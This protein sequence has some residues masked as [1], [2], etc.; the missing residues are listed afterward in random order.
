M[1]S[2]R[3]FLNEGG[4]LRLFDH[5]SAASSKQ[6]DKILDAVFFI[7]TMKPAEK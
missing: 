2:L 4:V 6:W 1:H 5:Q 7:K 3:A